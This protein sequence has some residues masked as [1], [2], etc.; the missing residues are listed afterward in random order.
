MVQGSNILINK[1][2]ENYEKYK[3]IAENSPDILLQTTKLGYITYM[4]KNV[5]PT[6][7]YNLDEIIG[8]HF[9]NF[10]PRSEMPRYLSKM[11]EMISGKIIKSFRT[12]ALHKNGKLIPAM[13]ELVRLAIPRIV[14]TQS[15]VDYL[16]EIVLE[17]YKNRNKL[18]GY[19]IAYEAP[20]LRH[21]TARFQPIT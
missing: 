10:V 9:R 7:G 17:V 14:Y 16:I 2:N 18:K 5:E 13:M 4:S 12:F 15:H 6:F 20:M 3:F 21:F 11:K 19:K 8:K 1:I